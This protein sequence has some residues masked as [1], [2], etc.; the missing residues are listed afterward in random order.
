[1]RSNIVLLVVGGPGVGKTT[2]LKKVAQAH[3]KKVLI[4]DPVGDVQWE[5]FPRMAL[6]YLPAWRRG[7]KRV[8]EA[9]TKEAL[10]M[11][12]LHVWNALLIFDDATNY[13]D[14]FRDESILRIITLRRHRNIDSIFV[15]HSLKAVPTDLYKYST[16]LLLFPTQDSEQELRRLSK[17]VNFEQI[18][19]LY[20][21]VCRVKEPQY[22]KLL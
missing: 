3:K 19:R 5:S 4:F 2:F 10:Q 9:N 18:L 7:I 22:I 11:I 16:H 21:E 20:R 14:Y 8:M 6:G 12:S 15:F 1:M 17:I 13:I